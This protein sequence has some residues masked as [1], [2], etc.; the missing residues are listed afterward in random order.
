MESVVRTAAVQ[1]RARAAAL[2]WY[3]TTMLAGSTCIAV[4]LLW[5]ISWH[6]TI[7]RDTFWTPA[8]LVIHLGGVL[9]GL[10]CG[11]LALRT[12]LAGTA[13][14]KGRNVRFWGFYAPFGA[15][16]SVWGAFAMLTSAPFDNWWHD[17]YGL[18]VKILSPPHSL[19]G[20]GMISAQLGAMLIALALQN[21]AGAAELRPLGLAHL[22]GAGIVTL[23]ALVLL[24]EK[25]EPQLRHGAT[26]Y[27]LMAAVLPF[28]L[29]AVARSSRL[30]WAATITAGFY[31]LLAAAMCWI[32]PLFSAQPK[33]GPINHPMDHMAPPLFPLL[34]VIPALAIDVF[35][36]RR[37][38]KRAGWLDAVLIGAGFLALFFVTHWYFAEFQLSPASRNAFFVS[39]QFWS[40][41]SNPGARRY[42]YW[43]A[44]SNPVTA[45]KLGIALLWAIASTRLGL[46]WGSWMSR[47]Q[48]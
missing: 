16:V 4:G 35:L 27:V 44:E 10:T 7:G 39:D 41:S 40:Y 43:D 30:R 14:E 36:Q 17:A 25:S 3:L 47:V 38:E 28:L 13:E 26:F 9:A 12:T 11:W 23:M 15:W 8:H 24:T 22:Y 2:P 19:L 18:D 46:W 29:V 37:E 34:L 20:A 45:A 1:P 5:D 33:L 31:M 42:T 32:L 6:M 48:R 21:R